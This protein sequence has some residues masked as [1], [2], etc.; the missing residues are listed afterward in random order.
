ML[1]KNIN[2]HYCTYK[3][4][5]TYKWDC[6]LQ[7]HIVQEQIVYQKLGNITHA[8]VFFHWVVHHHCPMSVLF[9][10]II[11]SGYIIFCHIDMT[12]YLILWFW[13]LISNI[14]SHKEYGDE[15]P[16]PLTYILL[17]K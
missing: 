12:I 8:A 13:T 11:F 3:E 1:L 10:I 6:T 5:F 2:V 4:K 9:Y 17:R 16:N 15:H 7:I 14:L